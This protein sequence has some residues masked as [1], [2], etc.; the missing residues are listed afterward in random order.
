[1]CSQQFQS[2]SLLLFLDYLLRKERTAIKITDFYFGLHITADLS[3]WILGCE[4][5][6][7]VGMSDIAMLDKIIPHVSS[8]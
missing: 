4:R 8:P 5:L 1:M 3:H 2:M 6:L 7:D